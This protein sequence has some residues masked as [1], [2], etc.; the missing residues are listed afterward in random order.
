MTLVREDWDFRS[1]QNGELIACCYW[2]Y[3]RESAFIRKLRERSWEYWRP[4]Y[5]RD[6]WWDAPKDKRLNAD[7]EKVQS[8]GYPAEVFLRG[9]SCP[10]DGV[11]PDAPPLKAGEVHPVTGSFPKPWLALT[12]EER[13]Y[14]AHIGNDV[15]RIP[16]VPFERGHSFDAKEI[17]KWVEAQRKEI[18]AA[19]ER[20]RQKYPKASEETLC[21]EGR[22]RF[23]ASQPSLYWAGGSEVTVVKIQWASFTDDEIAGYFRKWIKRNRPERAQAPNDQGRKLNDWRVA[24]NRLGIMRALHVYTFSDHRFPQVFKQR[25]DKHCYAGRKL[26][27]TK[28]RELFSFLPDSEKPISWQTRGQSRSSANVAA[29]SA[30]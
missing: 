8:I 1:V 21:R 18:D 9:I 27:L 19:N 3:A 11:L 6:K 2:E 30:G 12:Q 15:E 17:L 10:P 28:F 5:L 14:R 20:V 16:L 13:A 26:A 23:P 25:G 22:L 4:L 29:F 24:L 7:L